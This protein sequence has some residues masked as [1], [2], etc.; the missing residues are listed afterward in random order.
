M[1]SSSETPA[2]AEAEA[3]TARA[4]LVNTLNQLRENLKPSNMMDEVMTSAK[5]NATAITDQVWDTARR[6]PFPAL[7]IGAGLAMI[8]G[9]GTR[10]AAPGSRRVSRPSAAQIP[11]PT[12][13]H[14]AEP[15]FRRHI[16]RAP[17][18]TVRTGG[19]SLPSSAAQLAQ[20]GSTLLDTANERLSDVASRGA[21]RL[22]K[23]Y[24][25]AKRSDAMSWSNR[26]VGMTFNHLIEE[27]PLILAAVGVALGAAIGAALPN[28]QAEDSLM[29][30]TSGSVRTAA[31]GLVQDQ[32]TQ[33]KAA[34]SHAVADIKQSV[35]DHGVTADNL[36]GL[37]HDVGDKART[38]TYEAARPANS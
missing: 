28:T 10:Y 19:S 11:D 2:Q 17:S 12:L 21:A 37:V 14:D 4:G 6:N 20:R 3:E 25:S 29:G 22:S 16:A 27:Q 5:V 23:V 24:S 7:M 26:N 38:A 15:E 31:Q 36:S 30:E 1:S 13:G 32:L 8:L 34:A 35:A 33:A 9:V 18:S